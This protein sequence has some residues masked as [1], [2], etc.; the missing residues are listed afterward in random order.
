MAPV[1]QFRRRSSLPIILGAIVVALV[2]FA[3]TMTFLDWQNRP[4][5]KQTHVQILRPTPNESD[6]IEVID[7][8]TVRHGG[9]I[10]RLVGFD[11]PEVQYKARCDD[12]RRRADAAT[13]CLRDLV[14]GS[15]ARLIRVACSCKPG[16][17]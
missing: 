10:Y 16:Q 13:A 3:A 15:D 9:A 17:E 2:A 1:I 11:A 5:G 12:E 7:G 8:D 4:A 6:P 14:S